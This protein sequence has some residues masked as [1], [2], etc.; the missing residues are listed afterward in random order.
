MKTNMYILDLIS[1]RKQFENRIDTEIEETMKGRGDSTKL[2][3]SLNYII[4]TANVLKGCYKEYEKGENSGK[5][6]ENNTIIYRPVRSSIDEA[7]AEAKEFKDEA[8]M[9]EY[10]ADKYNSFLAEDLSIDSKS[11]DDDR[12]GWKDVHYVVTNRSR[13]D[14]YIELYGYPQCVGYC[15][16]NYRKTIM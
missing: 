9:F 5:S 7:M 13:K 3:D 11:H 16:Y 15:T 1:L 4:E 12:I 10:I 14:N 8:S 2:E 6:I